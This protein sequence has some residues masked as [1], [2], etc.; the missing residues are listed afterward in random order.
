MLV[1]AEENVINTNC[2]DKF[3]PQR[4]EVQQILVSTFTISVQYMKKSPALNKSIF[5]IL[6]LT[7]LKHPQQASKPIIHYELI[8]KNICAQE[9]SNSSHPRFYNYK[10]FSYI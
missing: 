2:L 1:S 6:S 8:F 9:Q 7:P 10:Y 5:S 4:N 3:P